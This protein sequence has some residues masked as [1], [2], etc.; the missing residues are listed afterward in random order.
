[1][2][3][4]ELVVHHPVHGVCSVYFDIREQFEEAK[5]IAKQRGI[6]RD[7]R[8]DYVIDASEFLSWLNGDLG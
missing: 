7:A 6:Y 8:R 3:L 2:S 1:M 5:R 4:W